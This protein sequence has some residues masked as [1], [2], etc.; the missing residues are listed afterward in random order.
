M[1]YADD[2]FKNHLHPM[3]CHFQHSGGL[4]MLMLCEMDNIDFVK[5]EECSVLKAHNVDRS[6]TGPKVFFG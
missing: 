3:L 5:Y 4:E 6:W 2:L 1:F